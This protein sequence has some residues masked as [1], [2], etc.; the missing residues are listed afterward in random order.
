MKLQTVPSQ[1]DGQGREGSP[2]PVTERASSYWV[3]RVFSA[4]ELW[5]LL[6]VFLHDI[7]TI[8]R[9]SDSDK[10]STASLDSQHTMVIILV[11]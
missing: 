4:V 2:D 9:Q 11:F 8:P 1:A 6:G 3:R 7:A 10:A 5:R